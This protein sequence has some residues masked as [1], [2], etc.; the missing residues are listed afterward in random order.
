MALD[1][2]WTTDALARLSPA[3]EVADVREAVLRVQQAV[4][5]WQAELAIG[6]PRRHPVST[7]GRCKRR[8]VVCRV[9]RAADLVNT[10]LTQA[11]KLAADNHLGDTDAPEAAAAIE[12][13]R[14]IA[15]WRTTAAATA[16]QQLGITGDPR[17]AHR[18]ST[19]RAIGDGLPPQMRLPNRLGQA[20]A[21]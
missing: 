17:D 13:L 10:D 18:A 16:R 21:A 14:R 1:T 5:A 3:E 4:S 8:C 11:V 12:Q 15:L 9:H 7:V 6:A 2:E 20:S 19:Q